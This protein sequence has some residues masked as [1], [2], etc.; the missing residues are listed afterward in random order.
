MKSKDQRKAAEGLL[1][2]GQIGDVL[3]ALLG[4]SNTENNALHMYGARLVLFTGTKQ[5]PAKSAPVG[6]GDKHS[7]QCLWP[8]H[9][10]RF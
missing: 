6:Q 9:R 4:R 5:K 1:A 8:S 10:I 7:L 3:P 2:T